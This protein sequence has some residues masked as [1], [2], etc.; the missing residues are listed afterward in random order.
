M[1]TRL[2]ENNA[3]DRG[4]NCVLSTVRDTLSALLC[5]ISGTFAQVQAR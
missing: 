5:G 4:A 2:S 1:E 3:C